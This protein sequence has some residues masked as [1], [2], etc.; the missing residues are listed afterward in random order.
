MGKNKNPQLYKLVEVKS[1][2]KYSHVFQNPISGKKE[3]FSPSDS[4]KVHKIKDL[5]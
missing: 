5:I 1:K 4:W 2:V 3:G